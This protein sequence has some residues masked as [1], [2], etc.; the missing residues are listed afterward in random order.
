MKAQQGTPPS[1]DELRHFMEFLRNVWAALAGVSVLFPLSNAF[2]QII[3]VARWSEG[4][5]AYF[6]PAIVSGAATLTCIFVIFW[7]FGQREHNGETNRTG[8]NAA[9]TAVR[10]FTVGIV[11][12][13]LYLVGHYSVSHDFYFR[14]LGWESDDLRWL[15][16]DVALLAAYVGFFAF[17]TR[18]FVVL[19]LREYLRPT[20]ETG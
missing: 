10:S 4:G 3:P 16:G 6:S 2:S 12:L 7:T 1:L 15:A 17:V 8:S 20:D 18:A 9:K 5:F 14:V 11:S 19:G 13:V